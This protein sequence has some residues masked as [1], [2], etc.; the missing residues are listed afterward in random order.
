MICCYDAVLPEIYAM[1]LNN[2]G[3]R[4]V[5]VLIVLIGMDIMS[6]VEDCLRHKGKQLYHHISEI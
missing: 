1:H 4:V 5:V 6:L 2:P 3:T